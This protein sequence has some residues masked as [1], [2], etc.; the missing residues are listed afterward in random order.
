[1][2]LN[3]LELTELFMD[4]FITEG[5][6]DYRD[7]ARILTACVSNIFIANLL[8]NILKVWSNDSWIIRTPF[9][10]QLHYSSCLMS[11]LSL[12]SPDLFDSEREQDLMNGVQN[13]LDHSDYQ[14]RL[15]A[16][17]VAEMLNQLHP[18]AENKLDFGLD[19]KNEIVAH[20]I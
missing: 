16:T 11:I 19:G 13:R 10:S 18:E 2:N 1:M 14:V 7:F 17:C 5:A 12:V 15:M 9:N 6:L 20:F 8:E 4:K 3:E